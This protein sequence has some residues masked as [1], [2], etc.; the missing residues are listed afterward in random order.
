[1]KFAALADLAAVGFII[2][3]LESIRLMMC[4]VVVVE[5]SLVEST[6]HAFV[7]A[8]VAVCSHKSSAFLKCQ[9]ASGIVLLLEDQ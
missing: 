9:S 7:V 2:I 8:V 4:V 1:M 5:Q 6:G 3:R